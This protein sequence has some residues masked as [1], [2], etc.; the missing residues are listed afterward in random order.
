MDTV[1]T[2]DL[3]QVGHD[4]K[5]PESVLATAAGDLFTSNSDGGV[6]HLHPDGSHSQYLGRTDEI[7]GTLHPNGI[8]LEPDGSFLL[9]HLGQSEGGV[10]R[11]QRDGRLEPELREVEGTELPPTNHVTRDARGRM[12]ITVSTTLSPRD[13]DFTPDAHRGYVVLDD[14]PPGAA[15]RA[16]VVAEGLGFTNECCPSPD[17]RWLYVNETFTRRTSRFPVSD[18]G[19]LGDKDVIAEFGPGEFP[20]GLALDVEGG[21]WVVCVVSNRVLRIAPDGTVDTWLDA[22][23]QAHIDEVE[24]IWAAGRMRADQIAGR[25]D[26]VL[27]QVSSLAFTGPQRRTVHLGSLRNE[28]LL[29]A[30]A[31]VAGVEPPHWRF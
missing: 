2:N 15:S 17:G 27:G 31:P 7:S 3:S 8:A 12:W 14:A 23:S 6:S 21:V 30:P 4:L 1:T 5:R 11:L 18:D 20:D 26:S 28:H 10:F 19:T 22:G 9:A 13:T 29:Y 24:P 25:A 16:R